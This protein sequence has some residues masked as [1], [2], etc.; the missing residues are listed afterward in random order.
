MDAMA[1]ELEQHK[2]SL[3]SLVVPLALLVKVVCRLQKL[4]ERWICQ[5]PQVCDTETLEAF[6]E[7]NTVVAEQFEVFEPCKVSELHK[8]GEV[9][10]DDAQGN[11]FGGNEL[12]A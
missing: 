5:E 4:W 11:H 7:L 6:S 8:L 12:F 3:P 1:T 2:G 9:I 10:N